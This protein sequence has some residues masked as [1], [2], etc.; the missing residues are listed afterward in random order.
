MLDFSHFENSVDKGIPIR[1]KAKY[2]ID[3]LTND[4]ML[5]EERDKAKKIR[6]KMAGVG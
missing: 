6:E 1:N 5:D 2:I 3:L 4:Q